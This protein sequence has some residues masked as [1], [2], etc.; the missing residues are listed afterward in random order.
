MKSIN[1]SVIL[2]Q[3][4]TDIYICQQLFLGMTIKYVTNKSYGDG[5]DRTV[6]LLNA[7]QALSQLS[8]A[9]TMILLTE[10]RFIIIHK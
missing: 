4:N 1:T 9:P 8:Y 7:I 10:G 5:R 2:F 3:N 6:D